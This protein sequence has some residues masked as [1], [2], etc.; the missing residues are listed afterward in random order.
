MHEGSYQTPATNRHNPHPPTHTHA[1]TKKTPK[2]HR[3]RAQDE[4]H[5]QRRAHD[6]V[7]RRL[8]HLD[9]LRQERVGDGAAAGDEEEDLQG[10]V[11]L[12]GGKVRGVKG[13]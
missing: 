12:F 10:G 11:D 6:G 3:R 5:R 4:A 13:G 9:Q 2:P 1:H 8:G 7:D